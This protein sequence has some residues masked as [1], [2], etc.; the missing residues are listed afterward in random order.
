M[1]GLRAKYFI[2]MSSKGTDYVTHQTSTAAEFLASGE[3]DDP[4]IISVDGVLFFTSKHAFIVGF[5]DNIRYMCVKK[6]SLEELIDDA[7]E[8]I[9]NNIHLDWPLYALRSTG[10]M[11]DFVFAF[12]ARKMLASSNQLFVLE[13]FRTVPSVVSQAVLNGGDPMSAAHCQEGQG[14]KLYYIKDAQPL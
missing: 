12:D 9:T 4:L 13:Y 10:I 6:L 2:D 5:N 1:D 3:Y 7:G 11:A 14:G 8:I